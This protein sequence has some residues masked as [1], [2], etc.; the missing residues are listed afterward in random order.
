MLSGMARML[1][2]N[3]SGGLSR[4][5]QSKHALYPVSSVI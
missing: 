2:F 3:L 4:A 1:S 5:M